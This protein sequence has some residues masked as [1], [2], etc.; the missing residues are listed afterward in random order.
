MKNNNP[1]RIR[2]PVHGSFED[3]GH[4]VAR[5][6]FMSEDYDDRTR[7]TSDITLVDQEDRY[8]D[9]EQAPQVA[10]QMQKQTQAK[11]H[12][13]TCQILRAS[14]FLQRLGPTSLAILQTP[15][16]QYEIEITALGRAKL[17]SLQQPNAI[18]EIV[19]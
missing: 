7:I 13:G 19:S 9:A 17:P 16:A 8:R 18:V 11:R 5:Q 12:S 6:V 2:C 10:S 14:H 15:L 3:Y 4:I 1:T